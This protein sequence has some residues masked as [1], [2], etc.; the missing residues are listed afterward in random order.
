M[1]EIEHPVQGSLVIYFDEFNKPTHSGIILQVQPSIIVQSKFNSIGIFKHEELAQV[2]ITYGLI[3][4]YY[5]PIDVAIAEKAFLD[6]VCGA[7]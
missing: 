1:N 3:T 2:P 6:F 4:K 7:K 5:N